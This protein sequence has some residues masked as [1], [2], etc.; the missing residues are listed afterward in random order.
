MSEG[1]KSE[2][3]ILL[4]NFFKNDSKMTPDLIISQVSIEN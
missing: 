1:V 4:I 2:I 3:G